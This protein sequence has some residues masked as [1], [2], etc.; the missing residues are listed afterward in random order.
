MK[1]SIHS[2]KPYKS[3]G[4]DGITPAHVQQV[5]FAEITKNRVLLGLIYRGNPE[6]TIPRNKW[7][8]VESNLS[9]ICLRM[10]RE[11]PGTS[12]CCMDAG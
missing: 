9:L 3:P 1:W 11:M 6:G 7:K 2:F 10:V 4:P 12:L 5:S 8:A